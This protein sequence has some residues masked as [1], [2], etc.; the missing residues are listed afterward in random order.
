MFRRR[1][2][3]RK[4]MSTPENLARLRCLVAAGGDGTVGDLI[5]N[6][7][8]VPLAVFPMGTENLLAKFLQV[9]RSG[10]KLADLIVDGETR[11]LDLA[12]IGARRFCLMASIGFDAEIVREVHAARRGNIRRWQYV[13]PIW[14]AW[15][16]SLR[17][18]PLRIVCDDDPAPLTGRSLFVINQPTYALRFQIAAQ[19]D[20]H[21]GRLDLRIYDWKSRWELLWLAW[22]AWCGGWDRLPQVTSRTVRRVRID[23]DRPV[24]V[25]IDG[26]PLGET[27]VEIAIVP[28][29]LAVYAP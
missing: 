12:Q 24:P 10:A 19:A 14:R 26:D 2:Q 6:Y 25:Q 27:P 21:D 4:W 20:G 1:E 18:P 3:L 7:P 11:R 9:P 15:R 28:D 8:G 17:T 5:T 23:S 29:A 22:N 16:Q 13:G